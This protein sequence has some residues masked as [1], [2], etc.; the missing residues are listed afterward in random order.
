MNIIY[1]L[2]LVMQTPYFGKCI[3]SHVS[4][5]SP[6]VPVGVDSQGRAIPGE[7][8]KL[9]GGEIVKYILVSIVCMGTHIYIRTWCLA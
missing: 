4:L 1:Q 7:V 2:M 6:P 3:M 5:S 9:F 8:P